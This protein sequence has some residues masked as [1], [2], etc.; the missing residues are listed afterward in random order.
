MGRRR[1]GKHPLKNKGRYVLLGLALFGA[2]S[3]WRDTRAEAHP[4]L[5]LAHMSCVRPGAFE[6]APEPPS[7][8]TGRLGLWVAVVDPETLQ[9][10]KAVATDPN[11]V[12]PL[13]SSYK[14]AVLWEALRQVDEG[15]LRLDETFDVDHGSQSLGNYPYDDSTTRTLLHRMIH[16][17]D[18]T[19]TDI[20]HRRVGLEAVQKLADD[21]DLCRTRL[22]L[23]TKTWWVAQ[24]GLDKNWPGAGVFAQASPEER[25]RI[26]H[27]LDETARGVR[28]DVLQQKLDDYFEE[29]YDEGA[30]IGTHNVSTPFEFG[31]LIAHEFLRPKL[32][33][34][35]R[36][37]Q[38][39]VMATGFGRSALHAPVTY[40]GGKGGNGWKILTMTGYFETPN[41][42]HVVYAFMQHGSHEDY[43]MG[44]IRAAFAWINDAVKAVLN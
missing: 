3:W 36:A 9:P 1:R 2:W 18:N 8:L 27:H 11:G 31:T 42:Q 7:R 33:S 29:R 15:K 37:V 25:A 13:A 23:P 12:Y 4:K 43:T 35:S 5:T 32:S 38:R 20:L 24:A 14:Q 10:V 17:S 41:G 39:E 19:A 44:N 40:F 28:A 6:A 30:D 26:A 16:N 34:A 22:I 21:L